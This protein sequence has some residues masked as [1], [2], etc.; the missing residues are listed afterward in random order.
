MIITEYYALCNCSHH[1]KVEYLN[2]SCFYP[3]SIRCPHQKYASWQRFTILI[4][5]NSVEYVWISWKVQAFL[6]IHYNVSLHSLNWCFLNKS[7]MDVFHF[8]CVMRLEETVMQEVIEVYAYFI[9]DKLKINTWICR[10]RCYSV[11]ASHKC[12]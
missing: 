9:F 7:F 12:V 8:E 6:F 4:L 3:K 10:G 5:T 1:M 11:Y 2:W